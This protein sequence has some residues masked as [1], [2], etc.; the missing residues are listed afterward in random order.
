MYRLFLVMFL[1]G[2]TS[3]QV[4]LTKNQIPEKCRVVDTKCQAPE[5]SPQI[6]ILPITPVSPIGPYGAV[7]ESKKLSKEE[8]VESI[9]KA[10]GQEPKKV[11]TKGLLLKVVDNYVLEV[12]HNEIVG[13]NNEVGFQ[14]NTWHEK[15]GLGLSDKVY[16]SAEWEAK[17]KPWIGKIVKVTH[18]EGFIG[19]GNVKFLLVSEIE[20]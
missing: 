7:P 11:I 3:Q 16:S 6:M 19:L 20:P 1:V 15:L 8:I 17:L 14:P 13:I 5:T 2:C 18:R 12:Q 10:I 9:Q 4:Q